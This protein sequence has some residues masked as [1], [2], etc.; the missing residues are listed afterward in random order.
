MT[1]A[2]PVVEAYESA[3]LPP[4]GLPTHEVAAKKADEPVFAGGVTVGPPEEAEASTP[5]EEELATLRKIPATMPWYAVCIC[6]VEFA[7]RASYYGS[8]GP[9]NNFINNPLPVDGNG[10]GAVASG[11]EGTNESAGALGLGSVDASALTT[12]FTFLAYVIPIFGGIIADTRWGRFKTIA[13]GT[14]VGFFAHILLVIPAIPSVIAHPNGSLAAFIIAIIILA[15][16]A[17]FIKP[18]LGPL[19]CDQCPI[20]VPTIHTTKKGERVIID[21]GVTVERWLLIFYGCINIG[22][23]F[24]VA[25]EYAERFVGFWLAFL[26]P[27]FIYLLMPIVLVIC[28]PK[29]YHAPPQGSV[30]LEAV[31]VFKRLLADGGWRRMWRGGDEFWNRAK[32]SYI[33]E[34]EGG[35][36]VSRVFWDDQFVDEI[37]QSVQACHIFA[38]IVIYALADGGIGNQLNDMS[39]AMVLGNA[40]N[41]LIGN[42]NPLMII[43]CSPIL[44]YGL[45]P[46]MSKIGYPL[47]PMTRMSIGF[48]LG[49]I[50]C[51]VC[52]IVQWRV[53]ATSPCGNYATTCDEVSSISL[54]LQVPIYALPALGELF[55]YVTS[56]ELAYTRSP[57]RMKGFV[58]S[59]CLFNS[60]IAAA[61]S[62]ALADVIQDPWLIW[63]WVALAVAC[64]MCIPIFLI[65][66]RHLNV[67][68]GEFANADRQ[69]GKQQ[70]QY[71][72]ATRANDD[73]EKY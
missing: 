29:L 67:P 28:R 73:H 1:G 19:L 36:D 64:V 32:P 16:A 57:A 30:F 12:L 24:A 72:A 11:A 44:T 48:F 60:A 27:A 37:K 2:E 4:T 66:Y 39:D 46:F 52:A 55:V 50:G 18:S 6:L 47:K 70:P 62:L 3:P 8:S 20:K 61:I 9:F 22:A 53:Y 33:A 13:V 42:F 7:E 65:F 26:L 69:E 63:P 51:V 54:W 15:F 5:T 23:F 25:T 17:G 49:A 21:P 35:L 45:Y 43:I 41:D 68:L 71:L 38:F 56:Y 59:L 58:Y 14:A 34:A 31:Q 40:P 10:A